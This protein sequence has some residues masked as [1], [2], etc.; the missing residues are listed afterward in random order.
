MVIDF[1]G[2]HYTL[3][4]VTNVFSGTSIERTPNWYPQ[5]LSIAAAVHYS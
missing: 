1:R 2:V 5:L 3:D 4:E